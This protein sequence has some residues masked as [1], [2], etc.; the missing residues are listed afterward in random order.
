MTDITDTE[1][2]TRYWRDDPTEQKAMDALRMLK[3]RGHVEI[4]WSHPLVPMARI[5]P[6]GRIAFERERRQLGI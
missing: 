4:D 3:L 6:L 1:L 5:T 2:D